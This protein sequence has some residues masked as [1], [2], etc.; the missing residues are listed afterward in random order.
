M[1]EVKVISLDVINNLEEWWVCYTTDRLNVEIILHLSPSDA[2]PLRASSC[3]CRLR[4]VAELNLAKGLL[5][6][7]ACLRHLELALCDER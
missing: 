3:G 1:N 4:R 6:G 2:S 7:Y 5:L